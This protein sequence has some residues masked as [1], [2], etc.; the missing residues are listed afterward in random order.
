LNTNEILLVAVAT[1]ACSIIKNGAAIGSG[2][3]LVPVLALVFP[4]KIALGL[5]APIMLASDIVGLWNYWGEWRGHVRDVLRLIVMGFFGIAL[6]AYFI[7]V[8]PGDVFKKGIGIFAISFSIYQF[9]KDAGVFGAKGDKG[10][11]TH[12]TQSDWR[13]WGPIGFLGGIATVLAHA[14]G[15]VWSTYF[16]GKHLEKRVLVSSLIL[17]F[18]MSD[19]MK[20]IAYMNLGI[21]SMESNLIVLCMIPIVV[22]S[23][24]FGNAL[25]KR[26]PP[27]QFRRVVLLLITAVGVNLLFS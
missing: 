18:S 24:N 13:A 16:V 12:E 6:G 17:L 10:R 23:S 20:V 25:N 9:L 7:H 3:F 2:I 26:I 15:M 21:L 8:I 1:A 14:G 19:L 27:V 11:V 4:P 22:V 5:G